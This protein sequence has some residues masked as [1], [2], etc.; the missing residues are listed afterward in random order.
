MN[1]SLNHFED[2]EGQLQLRTLHEAPLQKS[3]PQP[4]ARSLL[5]NAKS[6]VSLEE[7]YCGLCRIRRSVQVS[8]DDE[9]QAFLAVPYVTDEDKENHRR[10]AYMPSTCL[11]DM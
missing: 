6:K 2:K 9:T 3:F 10:H 1:I 8:E 11:L 4:F 5:N 7:S